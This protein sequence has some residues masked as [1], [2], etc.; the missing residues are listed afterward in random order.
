MKITVSQIKNLREKTGAPVIRVKKVLE[1][2]KGDE[3]KAFKILQKE[4]FE[5][6]IKRQDRETKAGVIASYLHHNKKVG[7]MVELLSETDFVA[8]NKLFVDLAYNLAM[9]VASLNPKDKK[10]LLEQEFIK[11]P[12]K[13]IADLIKEVIAKTGENVCL[14]RFQRLEIGG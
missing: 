5:K 8:R 6:A 2:F 14:G 12:K 10:E 13:K 9:Q 4:G 11:D 7:A 1:E 3:A